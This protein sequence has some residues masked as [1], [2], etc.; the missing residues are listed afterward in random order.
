MLALAFTSLVA[1]SVAADYPVWPEAVTW[2]GTFSVP[3]AQMES[4]I[5]TFYD[6]AGEVPKWG[7]R[8]EKYDINYIYVENVKFEFKRLNKTCTKTALTAFP[9]PK[10]QFENATLIST[11]DRVT[12]D[13]NPVNSWVAT[14]ALGYAVSFDTL[15]DANH[16][17]R[18]TVHIDEPGWH[19]EIRVYD[20][21]EMSITPADALEV[22]PYCYH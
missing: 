15:K 11:V 19:T 7:Q 12:S 21:V 2:K 10:N 14:S 9:Y 1:A 6:I 18:R 22:P 3:A 17:L 16:T 20:M 13:Q 4:P 5:S 8:I